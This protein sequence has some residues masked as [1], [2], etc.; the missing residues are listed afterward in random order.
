MDKQDQLCSEYDYLIVN[1]GAID[2]LLEREL[3]E[4]EAEFAN[5]IQI[6]FKVGL[7]PIVTTIPHVIV[8]NHPDEKIIRQTLMLFNKFLMNTYGNGTYH[9]IDLYASLFEGKIDDWISKYYKYV[10]ISTN[11]L[12][13]NLLCSES[14]L[15]QLLCDIFNVAN[16]KFYPWATKTWNCGDGMKKVGIGF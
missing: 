3:I 16:P 5:L 1:I 14:T 13:S 8:K 7:Q 15:I 11:N 9:F 2:I 12:P 4:I 6:I 10:F